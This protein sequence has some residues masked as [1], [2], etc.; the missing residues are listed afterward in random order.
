MLSGVRTDLLYRYRFLISCCLTDDI[1]YAYLL[2]VLSPI[3]D[4]LTPACH[5]LTPDS[6]M[7]SPAT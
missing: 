2:G 4:H 5:Y 7:L 3:C 1:F 6:F